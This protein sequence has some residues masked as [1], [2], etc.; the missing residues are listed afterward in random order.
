MILSASLLLKSAPWR[1]SSPLWQSYDLISQSEQSPHGS[2][3]IGVFTPKMVC[4]ISSPNF[5][6]FAGSAMNSLKYLPSK[7]IGTHVFGIIILCFGL[8]LFS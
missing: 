8:E 1:G 7:I 4:D 2:A 5:L 3:A 6:E